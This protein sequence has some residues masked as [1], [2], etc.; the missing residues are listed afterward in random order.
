MHPVR[1][2]ELVS[3]TVRCRRGRVRLLEA[4]TDKDSRAGHVGQ[5]GQRG[6]Q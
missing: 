1:R 6:L 2:N 4:G 3:V 5:R